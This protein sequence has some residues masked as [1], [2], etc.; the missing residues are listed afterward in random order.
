MLTLKAGLFGSRNNWETRGLELIIFPNPLSRIGMGVIRSP[1]YYQYIFFYFGA[2]GILF[3]AHI[4]ATLSFQV[5]NLFI[6]K[7]NWSFEFLTRIRT[8]S[9]YNFLPMKKCGDKLYTW[10]I[11]QTSCTLENFRVMEMEGRCR[12]VESL[13]F[14]LDGGRS[15]F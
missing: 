2:M 4:F 3:H 14:R 8:P 11:K 10:W 7:Y 12:I 13:G 15:Q 6:E 1:S 9:K 5:H